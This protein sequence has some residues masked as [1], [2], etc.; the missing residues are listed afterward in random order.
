MARFRIVE[1]IDDSGCSGR[2]DREWIIEEK[3]FWGW[4]EITNLE[5]PKSKRVTHKTRK[6]AETYLLDNYTGHGRCERY[7]N[8]YVYTKYSYSF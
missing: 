5:G 4:R 8:T 3:R 1:I 2:R 6:E 7:G